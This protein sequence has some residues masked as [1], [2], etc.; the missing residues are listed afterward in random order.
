[1]AYLL[2]NANIITPLTEKPIS[3]QTKVFEFKDHCLL[4]DKNK[5]KKIGNYREIKNEITKDTEI[6]DINHNYLLPG[7]VDCHTHPVF[8]GKRINDFIK[9]VEG[10]SYQDIAREGG[11]IKYTVEKTINSPNLKN[12][13]IQRIQ[14]F[15]QNGTTII[16]AKNGYAIELEKEIEHLKLI[17]EVSNF[18]KVQLIPTFLAH[19]PPENF[20]EY[21]KELKAKAKEIRNL[22]DFF[23]IFC[24]KTAFSVK[25]TLEIVEITKDYKFYYRFH[26]NEFDDDGLIEELYERYG[27]KIN[28]V[29]FDH[30]L[31]LKKKTIEAI[32]KIG[33]FAVIM[34]STSWFLGKN[35]SPVLEILEQ[36]IPVCLATDYNAG[37]SNAISL[38]FVAN[39]A[40]IYLKLKPEYI[41]SFITVNPS[42]LLNINSGQIREGFLAN[43]NVL[44]TD[45]WRE[46][47][48]SLDNNLIQPL[49]LN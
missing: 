36:D 15:Y 38:L 34:P 31:V 43:F 18:V 47:C 1:M 37:S 11:G 49:K 19:I 22:T 32:R 10:K 40:S 42:F 2:I 17:K 12:L 14:N 21:K 25:Q 46:F 16:E 9:R 5:I 30:L 26:T 44:K 6:I 48:F 35:Y 20:E 27:K 33:A 45:D 39:L 28:I 29:S 24:D 3:K 41:L 7:F 23:D 8:D 4:I 13:L